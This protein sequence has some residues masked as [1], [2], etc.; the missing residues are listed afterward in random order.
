MLHRSGFTVIELVVVLAIVAVLA[1]IGIPNY[2]AMQNRA[3][4]AA[5]LNSAH[6]VQL[7]AEDYSV[8]HDGVYS[9]LAADL[10]PL[11]PDALLLENPYTRQRTEPQFGWA[12]T[13]P[14]QVGISVVVQ[15][16]VNVGYLIT[17]FGREGLV[18][19]TENHR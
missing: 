10:V 11:F 2:V 19:V 18:V 3:K 6:T 13:Q 9:D 17:G 8:M 14:G 16:G 15:A 12:A 7:A 4:D 1:S 5:V